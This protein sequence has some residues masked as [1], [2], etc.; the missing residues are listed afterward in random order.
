MSDPVN[1]LDR[2]SR[3]KRD[4]ADEPAPGEANK[5]AGAP[6][7]VE[8]KPPAAET[9]FDPASLPPV[10]SIT[11]ESD[12]RAFLQPGVPPDL[13]RAALRRAWSSDP[14]IRDF[15]GLVENGWDFNDP[16]AMP[17]FG[18]IDASEVAQLLARV[19]GGPREE[20]AAP[21]QL[22]ALPD[23]GQV[24]PAAVVS[25]PAP[26]LSQDQPALEAELAAPEKEFAPCR[27]DDAAPQNESDN[28]EDLPPSRPRGHGGAL[29]K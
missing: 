11:A 29:P 24:P 27:E 28:R 10:E 5:T 20:T 12:I 15:V 7:P 18:P 14:A 21:R 3:R 22:A 16:T 26:Q 4:G 19:I 6:E 9:A 23:T 8:A 17:G 1:F 2:W 25:E 13:S